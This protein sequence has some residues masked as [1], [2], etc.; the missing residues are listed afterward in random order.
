[1]KITPSEILTS[2]STSNF[3]HVKFKLEHIPIAN[4]TL[5]KNHTKN[6]MDNVLNVE[7]AGIQVNIEGMLE[8]Q[9]I[10]PQESAVWFKLYGTDAYHNILYASIILN[11]VS[12]FEVDF[13]MTLSFLLA[14]F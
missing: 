4:L 6:I 1:M 14:K 3:H 7:L 9:K 2:P 11:S 13:F 8:I 5:N 10:I 12:Y